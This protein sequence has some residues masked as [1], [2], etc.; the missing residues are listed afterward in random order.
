MTSIWLFVMT[1]PHK[2]LYWLTHGVQA[3]ILGVVLTVISSTD[4]V[5]QYVQ[6]EEYARRRLAEEA[7][8]ALP[9]APPLSQGAAA[10]PAARANSAGQGKL[11]EGVCR[12]PCLVVAELLDLCPASP[13]GLDGRL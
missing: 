13:V 3:S 5:V 7:R 12:D 8:S 4:F 11:V 10:G 6:P 9:R 1:Y 2:G